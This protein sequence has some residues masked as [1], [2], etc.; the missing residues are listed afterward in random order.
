MLRAYIDS[1]QRSER[2]MKN[3]LFLV[4]GKT[5]PIITETVWALACNPE[6]PKPWI[7]D[8]IHVLSTEE[9]L[10]HIRMELFDN[11][12]S[13]GAVFEQFKKDYPQLKDVYFNGDDCLH[14]FQDKDG[15]KLADLRTPKD[16]EIAADII[17]QK[18]REFTDDDNTSLHVSIAGGRKTMGFY[19]GYALSLHGRAQ[20]SMSH[21]LVEE[22][23]ENAEGFFYP[24]LKDS[25]II[26]KNRAGKPVRTSEA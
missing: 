11:K 3:V 25:N 4:T 7:P 21:V 10:D 24:T 16:N 18:V 22:R 23:F 8:E 17:C 2:T 15:N 5:T 1:L 26:I 13:S 12:D 20:D 6:E 14:V 9:G 19:A